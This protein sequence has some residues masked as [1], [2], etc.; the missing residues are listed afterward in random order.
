MKKNKPMKIKT[1]V[2]PSGQFIYGIHTPRFKVD[3]FRENDFMEP[4]GQFSDGQLNE[5]Q[6][7]FP[8]GIVEELQADTIFEIP[9]PFA[10]RGTTYISKNWADEKA[11]NPGLISLPNLPDVSF[12]GFIEK[13]FG[14]NPK[15]LK[16]REILF[17]SLPEPMLLAMASTGTDPEDLV[18]LAKLSCDF[19]LIPKTTIL[20]G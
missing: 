6:S 5:N 13:W 19:F 14:N 4:L 18:A 7:N 2:L 17:E 12:A 8:P 16:N 10:F 20:R 3:N 1:C 15:L 11:K 9:N